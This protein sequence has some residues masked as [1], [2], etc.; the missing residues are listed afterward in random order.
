MSDQPHPGRPPV[1]VDAERAIRWTTDVFMTCGMDRADA[2]VVAVQLASDDLRGVMSHGLIRVSNYVQ[3]LQTRAIDPRG[4]PE[5][6]ERHG[7]TAVVDGQNA[8]GQVVA[9]YAMG[10]CLDLAADCGSGSVAV[11]HSNHFGTCAHFAQM[12]VAR[13]MIGMAATVSA[14]NIMAPWGAI[15]ALL[16]NNPF[17]IAVPTATHPPL[18]LDI[19]F[20]VAAGGKI[21]LA[22]KRGDPLPSDWAIGPDGLPET[23]A[24]RAAGNLLVRPVGDH[25]GYGLALMVA[26]MSALLPNAAF[27]REVRNMRTD[28]EQAQNVGHWFHAID[29]KCFSDPKDFRER[30]DRAIDAM[31]SARRG[32]GVERILV[33]GELEAEVEERRRREGIPYPEALRSELNALGHSLAVGPLDDS[34]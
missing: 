26:V 34:G 24:A 13:D 11:R 6:V 28:F 1:L 32:P 27:G 33:P 30:V 25:K 18:V 15:E 4:R 16:G 19:S 14:G 29:V 5:V 10:V 7:G 31:H 23:E 12:A 3:R 21:L 17:G 9:A 2:E 8:M 22:A 20:S